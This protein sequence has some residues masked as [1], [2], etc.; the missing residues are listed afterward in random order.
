M[1]MICVLC[2][3]IHELLLYL[4]VALNSTL[5]FIDVVQQFRGEYVNSEYPTVVNVYKF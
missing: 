3:H 4:L 5:Q 2:L 1:M